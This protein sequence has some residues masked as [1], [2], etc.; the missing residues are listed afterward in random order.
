[1]EALTDPYEID[2]VEA[3]KRKEIFK[4]IYDLNRNGKVDWKEYMLINKL[5]GTDLGESVTVFV[6]KDGNTDFTLAK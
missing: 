4:N 6:S 2:K 1:M 3:K 5:F